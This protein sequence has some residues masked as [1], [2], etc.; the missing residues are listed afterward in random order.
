MA[1]IQ[2]VTGSIDSDQLGVTLGHEHLRSSAES[3]REQFPHLYNAEAEELKAV[4]WIEAAKEH[5]LET[6][7]EPTCMDLGRDVGLMQRVAKS[8]GINIVACTGIYGAHYK[9][10]PQ[11]FSNAEPDYIAEAFV[12]DLTEGMQGTD[13]RAAFLKCAVDE[14]G[15]TEHIDKVLRACARASEQTGAPIMAHSHPASRS[16]LAI[17]DV[18]DDE[19]VDPSKVQVAHTGDTDDLDYITELLDRGPYIGMD[20]YGLDIILPADQR[21]AT[22]VELC[23][24]GYAERMILSH[25]A[26]AFI[27]WFPPLDQLEQTRQQLAPNWHYSYIF[28][29]IMPALHDAGVSEEQTRTMLG[30]STAA[31][32]TG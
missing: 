17:M 5:G 7:V 3:V 19:G 27:D 30:P 11:H 26:C 12:H 23:E 29:E 18:L 21:N 16:G 32:L 13:A 1:Q 20:R 8:T 4:E 22:V 14:P 25:D 6:I 24:R 10:I 9:T 31:W 2:T 15:V 28:E